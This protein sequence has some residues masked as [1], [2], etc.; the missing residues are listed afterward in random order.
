[1]LSCV[2]DEGVDSTLAA[3]GDEGVTILYADSH[4]LKRL[5]ASGATGADYPALRG[6][7]IKIGSGEDIGADTPRTW[8]S[9]SLTTVGKPAGDGHGHGHGH[10]HNHGHGHSHGH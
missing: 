3:I 2:A 4:T 5:E 7:L 10:G 1:M 9:L 6:G 8:G